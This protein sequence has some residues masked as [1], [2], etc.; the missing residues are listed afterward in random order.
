MKI[1]VIGGG[2]GGLAF[3]RAA[4][5]KGADVTILEQ[6]EAIKE[7]GAGLQISPNGIR[8]IEALGLKDELTQTSVRGR[9]VSLRNYSDAREV[10]RLDLTKLPDDQG[11]YFVHRADLVDLLAK[12]SRDAGV[13]IQLMQTVSE[14]SNDARPFVTTTKG[15]IFH[16]DLIVGA[17]GVHSVAREKIIG[18]SAPFFTHHVA[19]RATIPN[20]LHFPAEVR[21]YMGPKRHIVCYPLRGGVLLNIVAVQE[22]SEW[23]EEGWHVQDDPKNLESVFADFGNEV[24]AIL[25]R[26]KDVSIWGLF[27]HNVADPWHD[28]RTVLLGDAAHPTLPFMAQGANMAL[29]DA[30]VLADEVTSPKSIEVALAAYQLKRKDRAKRIIDTAS[31][32]AWKY[33]LSSPPVRWAAH[34]GMRVL[35]KVAPNKLLGQFDWIYDHDVT[36]SP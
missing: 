9:A 18:K 5:L 6:A 10:V 24:H 33:H 25:E 20:D 13:N 3:A 8:V 28:G 12:G 35:G 11:Y 19:W 7:V 2:I 27:R 23:A 26:V 30:W 4:A 15:D 14:I 16:A 21:V 17:D 34:A 1:C 32:N 22:R 36:K 31:N 29:E